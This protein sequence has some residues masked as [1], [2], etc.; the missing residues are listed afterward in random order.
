MNKKIAV[1]TANLGNFDKIIKPLKQTINYSFYRFTDENFPPRYCS[2]TPRLQARI[3]KTFSWQM[4]PNYDYYIWIDASCIFNRE[5]AVE[6][7]LKKCNN[8]DMA[9]FK[10]PHRNSI[11]EEADYLKKRLAMKCP[12]ITPR[13]DNELIDEQLAIIKEDKNYIDNRLFA[14]TIMIYKN[15]EKVQRMMK[16][17]WY[18]IS[19]FHSID[20][21]SLP[22]VIWQFG[23]NI[24]IIQEN[25]LKIP[26][27]KYIRNKKI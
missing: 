22:Y 4:I 2:M 10:H 8:V 19:R 12:Y 13:Y 9:V 18:H 11:Q 27:I 26:Y 16:E 15:N 3:V 17:W 20:Q 5:D 14:S 1:I 24:N 25:Y 7:L 23:I 6:W 21:L